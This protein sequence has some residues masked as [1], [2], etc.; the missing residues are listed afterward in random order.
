MIPTRAV[1]SLGARKIEVVPAIYDHALTLRNSME[2]PCLAARAI[3]LI[4][5]Y[6]AN[7]AS[8]TTESAEGGTLK[9]LHTLVAERLRQTPLGAAVMD[10]LEALPADNTR[11]Q[12]TATALGDL[13]NT[14]SDLEQQVDRAVT[15]AQKE[16]SPDINSSQAR[17][18][19]PGT[20]EA[21]VNRQLGGVAPHL[22][23]G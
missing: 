15:E 13:L 22:V 14:D 3:N 6:L 10:G 23:V 16:A 1:Y 5:T 19:R 4:S 11:Q 2:N 20:P 21:T 17:V 12:L 8:G 9:Q 18:S 7:V